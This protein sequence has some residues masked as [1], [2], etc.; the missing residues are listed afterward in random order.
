VGPE[1]EKD[2]G[3]RKSILCSSAAGQVR[4]I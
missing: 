1:N 2:F 4:P 3:A